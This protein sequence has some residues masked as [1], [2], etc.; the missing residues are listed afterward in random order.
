MIWTKNVASLGFKWMILQLKNK[1]LDY[2]HIDRSGIEETGEYDL[3]GNLYAL[4]MRSLR[5]CK[6]SGA[7][8]IET[9]FSG[10]PNPAVVRAELKRAVFQWLKKKHDNHHHRRA[11]RK[12]FTR[13][14]L[15]EYIF[16]LRHFS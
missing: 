7:D 6:A 15:E 1:F 12:T 2:V 9:L 3:R 4:T 10:I 8:T 14:G 13:H 11:G 5:R 16:R